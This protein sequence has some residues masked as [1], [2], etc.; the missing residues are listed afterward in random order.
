MQK[1]HCISPVQFTTVLH[2]STSFYNSAVFFC[3]QSTMHKWFETY[4]ESIIQ[5]RKQITIQLIIWN[6]VKS[7]FK[8]YSFCFSMA[9][10]W[11]AW[12]LMHMR[13]PPEEPHL[14][15]VR[16]YLMQSE[17]WGKPRQHRQETYCSYTALQC[18]NTKHWPLR[19][20]PTPHS[21]IAPFV[22]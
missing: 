11:D 20:R 15:C 4:K 7:E 10:W 5:N 18:L 9:L 19:Q 3:G 8:R 12:F 16:C 21:T 6:F 2:I 13:S 22:A 17:V 14:A 1:K